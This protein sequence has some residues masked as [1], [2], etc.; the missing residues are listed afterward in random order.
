MK[1]KK[2]IVT[3]TVAAA[4]MSS[5]LNVSAAKA[6]TE[7]Y[8]SAL[9]KDGKESIII[10]VEA[11][12]AAY[13]DLAAAFGDD[14]GAYIEHYLTFGVYE[15]RMEGALFDPLTYAAAYGD[16]RAAYGDD[17]L[18]IANHYKTA[19][20][21]ENR[22]MGT[23]NGYADIA[24]AEKAGAIVVAPRVNSQASAA[25]VNNGNKVN[26]ESSVN[27]GNVSN[28]NG[29]VNEISDNGVVN[30]QNNNG[31]SADASNGADTSSSS[32]ANNSA[33]VNNGSG[34]AQN[35]SAANT[36]S[37]GSSAVNANTSADSTSNNVEA[38]NSSVSNESNYQHVT[39]IYHDDGET[40]WRKEYY[41]ED[42]KLS[43]YSSITD[44]DNST[45]SYTENVYKWDT[46]KNE[47]VLQRTDTYV[48][49]ELVSSETP[50]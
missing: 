1:L 44:V 27:N 28:G 5:V 41:D 32:D 13:S 4:F 23:A 10:D 22:T 36:G 48:G 3:G 21:A 7:D 14:W 30:V 6:T 12:K 25:A 33:N 24:A 47:E 15:G 31:G 40:L 42:N 18:A 2:A 45:N 49:G 35:N 26:G 39:T 46:E 29:V 17:I 37:T 19:G 16:I 11:Y 20:I 50:Q 34:A 38:A 43:E 8:M 9:K